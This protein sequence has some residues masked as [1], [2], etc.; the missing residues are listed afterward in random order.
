MDDLRLGRVSGEVSVSETSNVVTIWAKYSYTYQGQLKEGKQ[1]WSCWF[2]NKTELQKGDWA[3]I[4]GDLTVKVTDW[5]TPEGV[6]KHLPDI[7]LN[8]PVIL[9][10]TPKFGAEAPK[11]EKPRDLDD[12]AKYNSMPF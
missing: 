4:E 12:E 6:L 10:R 8:N 2:E 3:L 1:K 5:T 11:V 7:N 9:E